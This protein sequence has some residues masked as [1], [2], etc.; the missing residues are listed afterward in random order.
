MYIWPVA[1]SS[2]AGYTFR[3]LGVWLP[4]SRTKDRCSYSLGEEWLMVKVSFLQTG[5]V[6]DSVWGLIGR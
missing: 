2:F 3:F 1:S 5:I 4:C 6:G